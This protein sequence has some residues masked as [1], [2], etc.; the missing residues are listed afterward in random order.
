MESKNTTNF[1]NLFGFGQ[2]PKPFESVLKPLQVGVT[3]KYLCITLLVR[4]ISCVEEMWG[5]SG[6]SFPSSK[7][8]NKLANVLTN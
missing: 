4:K 1:D 7:I 5:S 2:G 6:L 8:P 3:I